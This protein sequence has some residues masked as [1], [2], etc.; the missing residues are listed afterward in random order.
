MQKFKNRIQEK[1]TEET[2]KLSKKERVNPPYMFGLSFVQ[3]DDYQHVHAKYTAICKT[4]CHFMTISRRHLN[5]IHDRIL[6]K[7]QKDEIIMM[8]RL[9]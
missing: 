3:P 1:S 8:K 5:M 9:P 4:D 6:K 7:Q 2:T